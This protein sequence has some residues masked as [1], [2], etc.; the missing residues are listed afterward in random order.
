[1]INDGFSFDSI[2]CSDLF[3][4]PWLNLGYIA[5]DRRHNLKPKFAQVPEQSEFTFS[6]YLVA[7]W[8]L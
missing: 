6:V 8:H 7:A 3:R 2:T 4:I 5:R 1:M